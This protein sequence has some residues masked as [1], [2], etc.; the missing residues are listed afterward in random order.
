MVET[1]AAEERLGETSMPSEISSM[2]PA[3]IFGSTLLDQ[4]GQPNLIID[5]SQ[6]HNLIWTLTNNQNQELVV[7]PFDSGKVGQ[8]Q[9]HFK[10][11]F[12]PGALTEAPSIQGWEVFAL[13]GGQGEITSLYVALLG[14][15]PLSLAPNA[16]YKAT[17]S[18]TSAIKEDR[19][20]SKIRV[21]LTN[22]QG[23]TLGGT[24]IPNKILGL[25]DL[26]LVQD[27]TPTL[28]APPLAVD[29]VGRRTVL[30]DGLTSNSFVFALTNMMP[31][32]LP[33]T[34]ISTIFTVW[35]DAAPNE[36]TAGIPWAL[37]RI[38]DL[39]SPDFDL[40]PPCAKPGVEPC[41]EPSRDWK[42]EKTVSTL[43]G[44]VV[45]SPRWKITVVNP[46]K[47]KPNEPV[48]FTFKG[49]KTNLDPGVTRMYLRFENVSSYRPGVLIG[50]L[51]KSP[52]LYG[53]TQGKGLYL[54]AGVPQ[55]KTPPAPNY[56]SGLYV[57]QFG[58]G[59]AAVFNGDVG[60]GTGANRP[61]AKL[62]IEDGVQ[63]PDGGSLI[64][65]SRNPAGPSLRFGCQTAYSWFQ[66]H[67]GKP[68][69]INPV[70]GT[71]GIG[72]ATPGSSLS[73]DGGVAIGKEYAQNT[74]KV[75]AN[76]LAV[77]GR[78]GIG[79]T[80]PGSPL[81]VDGGVA[82][83]KTYAQNKTSVAG[84]NL[85]VEGKMSIGTTTPSAVLQIGDTTVKPKIFADVTTV[86]VVQRPADTVGLSIRKFDANSVLQ[87]CVYDKAGQKEE[88][89]Y[90]Q[91]E[92]GSGDLLIGN[93][94]KMR[95]S[96][97]GVL[98][99]GCSVAGKE[100]DAGKIG[101]KTL[102]DSLDIVGAGDKAS[103]RKVRVWD[104]LQ[105]ANL[106]LTGGATIKG[107][108]R[109]VLEFG[110]GVHGKQGDAGKIG[111]KVFSQGLDIVG[112]TSDLNN[113]QIH[114]FDEVYCHGTFWSVS[115][116]FWCYLQPNNAVGQ[117]SW[118]WAVFRYSDA[119]LKKN[120]TPIESA[121][122]KV[123]KLNGCTYHWSAEAVKHFTK[124]IDTL[125]PAERD[126]TAEQVESLRQAE[127]ERQEQ[128]L[129][130]PQVGIIAQEVEAVLPEAVT[131]EPDGYKSVNYNHLIA[132]LVEAVKE[133]QTEIEKL[134]QALAQA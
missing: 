130:Q 82:I 51:E 44:E 89:N 68:L 109:Q 45:V 132:L 42:I 78:I 117:G 87:F 67:A 23:V 47:L 95:A 131:T 108:A 126:L 10:F 64:I 29:F 76:N 8:N 30:N 72:T 73:V 61:I 106:E 92:K 116:G 100:K 103:G 59:A 94:G 104:Q 98:E 86:G 107:D 74:T 6:S 20:N 115:N 90:I 69:A 12:T 81:S 88:C 99:L 5:S 54:T 16:F 7:T 133:Q 18:Y 63:N 84:N 58:T 1:H 43:K 38:E 110:Y 34:P 41:P 24:P 32:E 31:G 19:N 25:T 36:G 52:L 96:T 55:G 21:N 56:D 37:A 50:E 48:L 128:A 119:R 3:S 53:A 4:S 75:A 46:I 33:L 124:H 101:Y 2:G 39:D 121:L 129:A 127:R 66:S 120:V 27:H 28:S 125:Q 11:D 79:T 9:Y 111:Y 22:G 49:L 70:P 62:H 15:K 91:A 123:R 26:S 35:F 118:D 77:E 85:A 114:L 65:G 122:D 60:I 97:G 57:Q 40:S 14:S 13:K 17:L 80:S 134:K 113:R 105:T 102:S 83:G 71:V 93:A 112:A